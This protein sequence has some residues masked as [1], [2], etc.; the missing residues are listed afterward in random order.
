MHILKHVSKKGV[1]NMY[2]TFINIIIGFFIG[3]TA[4][5]AYERQKTKKDMRE[6]EKQKIYREV[7]GEETFKE[8]YVYPYQEEPI[9]YTEVDYLELE[10]EDMRK[11][12]TISFFLTL[13]FGSVGYLYTSTTAFAIAFVS[14]VFLLVIGITINGTLFEHFVNYPRPENML[15]LGI[16]IVRITH[17][18]IATAFTIQ[19]NNKI[20]E[21]LGLE[22]R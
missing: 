21:S 7:Y 2:R 12:P 14:N 20:R 9:T 19:T 11:K 13:V 6:L 15:A 8:K 5:Q 4:R 10:Y 17:T 1:C 22:M 3:R 18:V 16:F